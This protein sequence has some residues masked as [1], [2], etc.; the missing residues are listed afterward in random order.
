[1]YDTFGDKR[2]L[3]AKRSGDISWRASPG[4]SS[5]YDQWLHLSPEL[6]ALVSA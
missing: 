2:R 5:G 3:Y 4:T 1:M 6:E